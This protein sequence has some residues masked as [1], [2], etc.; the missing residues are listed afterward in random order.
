[1]SEDP[2]VS[3]VLPTY[4]RGHVL[5]HAIESVLAQT[6]EQ[7][8]LIV[9]DG[10]STDETPTVI[11]SFADSRITYLRREEPTGVSAARNVGVQEGEGDLIAFID[12]DDRW[13]DEKLAM[14]VDALTAAPRTCGVVYTG[15]TKEYGD[16]LDRDGSSG[17]VRETMRRLEVPTYTST[18][19]MTREAF[20]TVG[21]F[22]ERLPCFEDWE[23]CLRLSQNYRFA[24][25][26]EPLVEKGTSDDNISA[27]PERLSTAIR[28][29]RQKHEGLPSTTLARLLTD[30]GITYCEAGRLHEGRPYLRRS[31]RHNPRQPT[32]LCALV[33]TFTAPLIF[34]A[35]M[36]QIYAAKRQLD[37]REGG[38]SALPIGPVVDN[39]AR[40]LPLGSQSVGDRKMDET[41]DEGSTPENSS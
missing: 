25:V 9:V 16:P 30:A 35:L 19:L 26:D 2:L 3:V 6:Y 21:G 7:F 24:Y 12:S 15:M 37:E 39:I 29:I 38:I 17:D 11:E 22:D 34:D 1:M 28:R 27:E 20:K 5:E 14:Q 40:R 18:L 13:F 41:A 23:L 8:E 33:L 36:P 10:G 32:A 31:L 4:E